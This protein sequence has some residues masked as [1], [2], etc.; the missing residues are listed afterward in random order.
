[1]T[2]SRLTPLTLIEITAYHATRLHHS[3]EAPDLAVR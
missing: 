2:L 3:D 1:M